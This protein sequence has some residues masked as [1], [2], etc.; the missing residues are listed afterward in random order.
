VYYI[1]YLLFVFLITP[2]N[3]ET[4]LTSLFCLENRELVFDQAPEV[5]LGSCEGVNDVK[6]SF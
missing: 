4:K 2:I 3:S 6:N 1:A 5:I